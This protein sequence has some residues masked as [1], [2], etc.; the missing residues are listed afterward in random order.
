[1][2]TK[3]KKNLLTLTIKTV[4]GTTVTATDTV[5]DP[6]ASDARSQFQSFTTMVVRGENKKTYIPFHAVDTI[7]V[8]SAQSEEITR[9]DPICPEE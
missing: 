8:T 2:A 1:M 6:A 5:D 3:Y 4:G 7:E 9:P